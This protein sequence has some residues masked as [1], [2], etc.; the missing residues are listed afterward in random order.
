MKRLLQRCLSSFVVALVYVALVGCGPASSTGTTE[1]Q[2]AITATFDTQELQTGQNTLV[3]T[4][5]RAA[6][7]ALITDATLKVYPHMP[8]H[9]HGSTEEPKI[10]SMGEGK[11]K[12]SPVTFHMPGEWEIVVNAASGPEVGKLT[13]QVDVK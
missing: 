8:A 10:Q 2:L 1:G 3:I 7:G 13:F 12:A 6:T 5:K 11:Y 4:V 9:G